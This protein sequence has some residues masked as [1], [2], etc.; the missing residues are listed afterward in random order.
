MAKKPSYDELKREI[1]RLKK[2]VALQNRAEGER[3][4]TLDVLRAFMDNSPALIYIKDREGRFVDINSLTEIHLNASRK[5]V[6]GKTAYDFFPKEIAD[7]MAADDQE[8]LSGKLVE[9]EIVF[10]HEDRPKILLD[11]KFPILADNGAPS[12][13]CGIAT[14]IT[15][16]KETERAL[17]E[18]EERYRRLA[19][20]VADGVMLVQYGKIIFANQSLLSLLGYAHPGQLIDKEAHCF[21]SEP[22][23]SPFTKLCETLLAGNAG[24]D[25]FQA[26]C[27][28]TQR[29]E[30]WIEAHFS[31]IR[32]MGKPAV[33]ATIRDISD[34]K[35]REKIMEEEAEYLRRESIKLKETVKDRYRLG[36]IIGK[37]PPMQEVYEHVLKAASTDAPVVIQGE[38]GTGKE[39]VARAI[40]DLSRKAEGNFMPVNCGAIPGELVESEFFGY[41]KGAFSGAHRDREGF[42]ARAN[43]GTLFLDEVGEIPLAMQVKLL[44]AV[45]TGEHIMLGD[46]TPRKADVRVV[47]ATS[48]DLFH[49]VNNGRMREDFFYRISVITISLPPLRSR[50]E[51]IP[52]LAFHF[53]NQYT[54]G[55]KRDLPG[56]IMDE[57]YN[58]AWPGNVRELQSA[59]RRYIAVGSLGIGKP[60]KSLETYHP[61]RGTK[62]PMTSL[63]AAMKKLE[64][65]YLRQ[66]LEANRWKRGRTA[67][68]LEISPRT[69]H[70]KMA[71]MGLL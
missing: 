42:L 67:A 15:H 8:V 57:I 63:Q 21:M 59:I 45:E 30:F 66:A 2:V 71:K 38:S 69:L 17:R 9:H 11:H 3:A 1:G 33:L 43:G 65:E 46:T 60:G 23:K 26:L 14:D 52:L 20:D 55:T 4:R 16:L 41:R 39:L 51:D 10:Y 28:S 31:T 19:T 53:L 34:Q 32:W 68:I 58:H 7:K 54:Q 13:V 61:A 35:R 49:L 5:A 25:R 37:S 44:R 29:G 47:A 24:S 12:A 36:G 50:K 70:R 6:K 22:F 40:H 18:S 64:K 56:K 48:K 27:T 62:Q